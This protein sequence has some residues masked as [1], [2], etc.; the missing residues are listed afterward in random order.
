MDLQQ[1]YILGPEVAEKQITKDQTLMQLFKHA[2]ET[3]IERQ[4]QDDWRETTRQYEKMLNYPSSITTWQ[5]NEFNMQL[6]VMQV[7]PEG[8]NGWGQYET[9][10]MQVDE[11]DEHNQ[12]DVDNWDAEA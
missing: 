5:E 1:G 9:E 4:H 7:D 12:W 8:R 3:A 6:A 10:L 2:L 11:E